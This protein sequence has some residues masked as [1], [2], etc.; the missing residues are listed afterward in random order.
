M[1]K[2]EQLQKLMRIR[3]IRARKA[4]SY[5]SEIERKVKTLQKEYNLQSL[6]IE[7]KNN[8]I[9]RFAEERFAELN[10]R[11]TTDT[12]FTSITTGIFQRRRH[13]AGRKLQLAKSNQQLK[14]A[15]TQ[16]F[17]ARRNAID[18]NMSLES[19]TQISDCNKK[20]DAIR[21]EMFAEEEI[22]ELI[23]NRNE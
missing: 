21:H 15:Q 17:E 1:R 22:Q 9:I 4:N 7:E 2:P 11:A 16:L 23:C 8:D 3:A 6:E 13:L 19:L 18:L 12:I 20:I 5:V 10:T 14:S